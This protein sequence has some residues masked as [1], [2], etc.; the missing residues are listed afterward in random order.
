[1]P[2]SACTSQ[3]VLAPAA[4]SAMVASPRLTEAIGQRQEGKRRQR[5]AT[6]NGTGIRARELEPIGPV[7]GLC[8]AKCAP[9]ASYRR[10]IVAVIRHP[11]CTTL[12]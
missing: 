1:M 12:T 4:D 5:R 11:I 2:I 10:N 8:Q 6:E 3:A 9:E 7:T